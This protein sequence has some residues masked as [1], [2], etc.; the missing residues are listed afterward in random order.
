MV[1]E[2]PRIIEALWNSGGRGRAPGLPIKRNIR[3]AAPCLSQETRMMHVGSGHH[4][5][6]AHAQ[7]DACARQLGRALHPDR[8][9]FVLGGRLPARICFIDGSNDGHDCIAGLL[10]VQN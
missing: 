1:M 4:V 10:I 3:L 6:G 5:A 8:L 7:A 2:R 9:Q